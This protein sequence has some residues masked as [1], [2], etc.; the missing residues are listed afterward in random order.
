MREL[1]SYAFARLPVNRLY[2]LPF[3]HNPASIAL[4]A[5]LGYR[6]EGELVDSII[7]DGQIRSQVVYAI[8]RAEWRG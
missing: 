8:T 1:T 5:R 4:L 2:A 7:K 3:A 6:R